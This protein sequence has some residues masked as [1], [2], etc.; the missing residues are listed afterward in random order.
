MTEQE[1]A[2][3]AAGH[4]LNA[5]SHEDEARYWEALAAH[6][7]WEHVVREDAATAAALADGAA[8]VAPPL[9]ARSMLLVRV[10]ALAR[11]Q[12]APLTRA[13]AA[14]DTD[15]ADTPTHVVGVV[16]AVGAVGADAREGDAGPVEDGAA[17][18]DAAVDDGAA[19]DAGAGEPTAGLDEPGQSEPH[20]P[21]VDDPDESDAGADTATRVL[22]AA[23]AGDSD[24]DTGADTDTDFD[25]EVEDTPTRV[26]D[27]F[28]DDPDEVDAGELPVA[29]VV[30][31]PVF[32]APMPPVP[33]SPPAPAAGEPTPSP[34]TPADAAEA[35]DAEPAPRTGSTPT[36][37]T[38]LIAWATV[39]T[40]PAP[41]QPA[42]RE[43]GVDEPPTTTTVQAAMRRRWTR[44]LLALAACLTLLAGVGFGAGVVH[45]WLNRPASVVALDEINK[46]PDVQ[47]ATVVMEGGLTATAYWSAER[48]E[49]VVVSDGLPT[50]PEDETFE[51][52][53]I[54]DDEPQSAGTFEPQSGSRATTVIDREVQPGD[55]IAITIEPEGGAPRGTP[56]SDPIV[57]V[58]TA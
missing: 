21:G 28:E 32:A 40:S 24:A 25:T 16:G 30:P 7:E 22:D 54:R 41:V 45:T 42:S 47:S 17:E 43:D 56:T 2:E 10:A 1:F 52:W 38:G 20:A 35:P 4:A 58:P 11:E 29:G 46:A 51:M 39:D 14:F 33:V 31:P 13:P 23:G 34:E 12:S 18:D 5:L 44:G 49:A 50:I 57:A 36:T 37:M 9:T 8:P 19:E 15:P 53:V 26:T 48:G 27:L 55:V 3:L 6:P